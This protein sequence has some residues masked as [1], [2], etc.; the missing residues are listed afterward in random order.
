MYAAAVPDRV[1]KM[2]AAPAMELQTEETPLALQRLWSLTRARLAGTSTVLDAQPA[3]VEHLP[4]AQEPESTPKSFVHALNE[5]DYESDGE[6]AFLETELPVSIGPSF[7]TKTPFQRDDVTSYMGGG[8]GPIENAPR[9]KGRLSHGRRLICAAS[10]SRRPLS[11]GVIVCRL[12]NTTSRLTHIFLIDRR[13][14]MTFETDDISFWG[15]RD[16]ARESIHRC[17][18]AG[19]GRWRFASTRSMYIN[20]PVS[21][22]GVGLWTGKSRHLFGFDRPAIGADWGKWES[23]VAITFVHNWEAVPDISTKYWSV[24]EEL[25]LDASTL[26]DIP[27]VYRVPQLLPHQMPVVGVY[28]DPRVRTGFRYKVRPMQGSRSSDERRCPLLAFTET[29]IS[30]T[31]NAPP[32]LAHVEATVAP[33]RCRRWRCA[34]RTEALDA[35][36]LSL[37]PRYLFGGKALTLQSI[38]RGFARRLTFEPL[39][40]TLNENDN[41]FWTD[42]RPEGFAFEIEAVSV[43]DKF[44]VYDANHEP[45]G[46]LEIVEQ[47]KN[48]VELEQNINKDG[49]IEKK[50]KIKCLCKVEWYEDDGATKLVPVTGNA[51]LVKS[52]G[53]STASVQRVV[54]VAIGIKQLRKGYELKPG[55]EYT[56]RRITVSGTDIGDIPCSY[57]IVGLER[58]E[59]P[60]IGTYID[61]R[62]VP[63]FHY[64]VRP[65]GNRRHLFQGRSLLLQSIG[66]G[67]GKRLTFKPDTLNAPENYL[68]SDSHPEGLGMEPRAIHTG[69][70]F[71]ISGNGS[72]LIDKRVANYYKERVTISRRSG[73]CLQ[74]ITIKCQSSHYSCRFTNSFGLH[75]PLDR[76]QNANDV[77]FGVLGNLRDFVISTLFHPDA[78][79]IAASSC[80]ETIPESIDAGLLGEASVFRADLPQIEE[81]TEYVEV[82]GKRGKAVEKYIHAEVT[83]HVKLATTGG[84]SVD[85]EVHLMKVSGVVLVRK[86]PGRS[87]ARVVKMF[88]V[89]LDSQLNLLFAHSQTELTF[90]PMP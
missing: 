23:F 7:L 58:Y 50:V 68:W 52:R 83:C 8:G 48:Q 10:V 25:V 9:D 32:T 19:A 76:L 41:Y 47:Q 62:I 49:S 43:G 1:T 80:C 73:I 74:R 45:Q 30:S 46:T 90:H 11:P 44:T 27:A 54:N 13:L 28:I 3:L 31:A 87:T 53:K 64:R 88:N 66:M 20:S 60:V 59:L 29:K 12:V 16:L 35:P 51:I 67:Y 4:P 63:G 17:I 24:G 37:K 42:S 40:S 61:P 14:P 65:A 85:S 6:E 55:I 84:G 22:R 2:L 78:E 77:D 70:K 72:T 56:S 57:C 36:P 89:G 5:H 39:D 26:G 15:S 69:M 81:K 86:D 38:G 21:R 79:A 82:P 34:I 71:T 33:C 18:L 75:P